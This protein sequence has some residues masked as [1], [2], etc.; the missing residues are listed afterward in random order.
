MER[1][2]TVKNDDQISDTPQ[3]AI[4]NRVNQTFDQMAE[5]VRNMIGENEEKKDQ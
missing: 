5:D 4:M 1:E 2:L 3:D